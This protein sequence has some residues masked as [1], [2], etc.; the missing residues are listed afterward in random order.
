V[1]AAITRPGIQALAGALKDK[2]NLAILNIAINDFG[3][4]GR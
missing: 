2:S 3:T 4:E 1:S